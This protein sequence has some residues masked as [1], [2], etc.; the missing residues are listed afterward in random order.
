MQTIFDLKRQIQDKTDINQ[1][2]EDKIS[3]LIEAQAVYQEIET[4]IPLVAQALPPIPDA[5]RAL[6][7]L[8]S[9]AHE[10]NVTFAGMSVPTLPL[11]EE[12][13]PAKKAS[14]TRKVAEYV[15][16]LS[17]VGTYTDVKRFLTGLLEL[18]RIIQIERMAFIPKRQS[19]EIATGSATPAPTG[20]SVQVDLKLKLFYLTK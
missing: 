16:T 7:Q 6:A 19:A 9:L 2:M 15:I 8:R 4:K 10:T 14:T 13:T 1:K 18:R 20:T 5:T 17:V 11:I 3:A 12:D